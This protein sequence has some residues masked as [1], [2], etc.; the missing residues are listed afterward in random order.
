MSELFCGCKYIY[1]ICICK[2]NFVPPVGLEPTRFSAPR[3]ERGMSSIPPR[4]HEVFRLGIFDAANLVVCIFIKKSLQDLQRTPAPPDGNHHLLFINQQ[5]KR[6]GYFTTSPLKPI[7]Q[8][9][10]THSLKKQTSYWPGNERVSQP[11]ILIYVHD[12][13]I[14]SDYFT[15]FHDIT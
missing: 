2:C 11:D 15:F 6:G 7:K 4:G 8:D 1:N 12:T 10:I 9:M 3:S 14:V 13:E 5:I